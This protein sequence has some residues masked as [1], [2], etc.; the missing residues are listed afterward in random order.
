MKE[1]N[2]AYFTVN[3]GVSTVIHTTVP[4]EYPATSS[5]GVA[6]IFN[7]HGWKDHMAAFNDVS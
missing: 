6:T 3:F 2:M 4:I 5:D 7:V 1:T